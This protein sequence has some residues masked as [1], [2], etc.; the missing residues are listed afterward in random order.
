MKQPAS[1]R[2]QV[3][4]LASRRGSGFWRCSELLCRSQT[5]LRS[6]FVVAVVWAGSCRSD[7]T[8]SLGTSICYTYGP[9]QTNKKEFKKFQKVVITY[10]IYHVNHFKVCVWRSSVKCTHVLISTASQPRVRTMRMKQLFLLSPSS[11]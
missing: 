4:S 1:T 8:P 5:W 2:T 6:R 10:A 7:L 3:G 9:K 11:W